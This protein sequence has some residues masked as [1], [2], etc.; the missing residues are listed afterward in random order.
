MPY[1]HSGWRNRKR[2]LPAEA[3]AQSGSVC[4]LTIA[5]RDRRAVFEDHDLAAAA[6]EVLR[7]LSAKRRVPL[8]GYCVMPDHVHLVVGPSSECDIVTF[9]GQ[10]KNLVL[11]AAWTRGVTGSFWQSSFWDHFLRSDEDLGAAVEYV[12][13]NPVRRGLVIDWRD[14]P[15]AGSLT[16]D[17]GA[18]DQERAAGD[19]PPRYDRLA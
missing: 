11:R 18:Q 8:F 5:V 9:V 1:E 10:Y 6:V 2:R 14:Y 13:T 4:S 16:Y 17:S 19:K 15:F 7:A 3:Y 12:L